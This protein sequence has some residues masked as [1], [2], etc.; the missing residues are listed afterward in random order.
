M[1][2]ATATA[3]TASTASASTG[4]APGTPGATAAGATH[5]IQ[6]NVLTKDKLRQILMVI[7]AL[8]SKGATEQNNAEYAKLMHIMRVVNAQQQQQQQQQIQQQQ[9][10]IQQQQQQIQQQQQPSA[11]TSAN[12]IY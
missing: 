4:I 7:Q 2:T 12:G 1:P 8:R 11:D 3:S 10:Q 5:A 6:D 9:Q